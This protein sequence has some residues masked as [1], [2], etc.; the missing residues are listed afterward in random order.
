[1]KP[2]QPTR[3][4]RPPPT[5]HLQTDQVPHPDKRQAPQDDRRGRRWGERPGEGRCPCGPPARRRPIRR[6]LEGLRRLA[7]A[8]DQ[9]IVFGWVLGDIFAE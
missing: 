6:A 7:P 2:S 4:A 1:M 5:P 9:M 3:L 8:G